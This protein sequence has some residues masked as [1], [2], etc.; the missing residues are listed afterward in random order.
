MFVSDVQ[1]E[2][3]MEVREEQADG[4]EEEPAAGIVTMIRE[5]EEGELAISG[6]VRKI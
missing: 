2:T 1:E 3:R 5:V 6:W 4:T